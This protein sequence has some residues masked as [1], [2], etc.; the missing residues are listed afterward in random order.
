MTGR[1]FNVWKKAW[2]QLEVTCKWNKAR[3]IWPKTTVSFTRHCG[4]SERHGG[5][6]PRCRGATVKFEACNYSISPSR[7]LPLSIP[8]PPTLHPTPSHSP[9]RSLPLSIP[10]PP[11]LHPAP[12]HSLPHSLPLS[13]PLPPTLHPTPSHSPSRSLPLSTPLPPALPLSPSLAF[14]PS[15]SSFPSYEGEKQIND[16]RKWRSVSGT[17]EQLYSMQI[18]LFLLNL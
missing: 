8:L 14:P 16:H 3:P 6:L 4:Q 5:K 17:H 13:I 18:N 11:T 1:H 2:R 15:L 10:L 12:S 9:S 7:S